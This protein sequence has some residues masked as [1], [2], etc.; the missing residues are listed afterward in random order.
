MMMV[1]LQL[2]QQQQSVTT[3]STHDTK[4]E[5]TSDAAINDVE[6]PMTVMAERKTHANETASDETKD[7]ATDEMIN[8]TTKNSKSKRRQCEHDKIAWLLAS[9]AREIKDKANGTA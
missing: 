8:N 7:K 3:M 1:Q 9:K 6:A 4:Q 5:A 2:Q